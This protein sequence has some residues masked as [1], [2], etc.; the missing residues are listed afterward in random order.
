MK[1]KTRDRDP[2]TR[3]QTARDRD[4]R[5]RGDEREVQGE[6]VNIRHPELVKK[7]IECADEITCQPHDIRGRGREKGCCGDCSGIEHKG[8]HAAFVG[9]SSDLIGNIDALTEAVAVLEKG[10]TGGSF[11]QDGV[12]VVRRTAV[13]NAEKACDSER[14]SVL[15]FLSGVL[16]DD[17]RYA[18]QNGE[19]VGS[20]KQLKGETS[21][22]QSKEHHEGANL[23]LFTEFKTARA[24]VQEVRLDP[25]LRS[26]VASA[27]REERSH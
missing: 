20:L 21:A 2:R 7:Q 19:I 1:K 6:S 14:T 22:D 25:L 23:D 3:E 4:P 12:G 11:L 5:S 13:K 17:G 9:Q 8:A 15:S 27:T 18:P 26:T 24:I 10:M 16:S